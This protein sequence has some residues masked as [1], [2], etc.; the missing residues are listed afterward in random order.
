MKEP[1][2]DFYQAFHSNHG[3]IIMDCPCGRVHF[4]YMDSH[5]FEPGEL[6]AL[7]EKQKNN[8][9]K[10]IGC[11]YTV[12]SYMIGKTEFVMGCPCNFGRQFEDFINQNDWRIAR[13]LNEKAK[14][15]R[16]HADNIQTTSQ[17]D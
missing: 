1:S 11:D 2:E 12:T 8:P 16:R 9:D 14:R 13:Y 3:S 15:L 6:E 10:Y 7:E 17:P 4:N 5:C